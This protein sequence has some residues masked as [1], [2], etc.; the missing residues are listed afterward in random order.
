MQRPFAFMA[1][2]Y[3]NG[4]LR[5]HTHNP[6]HVLPSLDRRPSSTLPP[7]LPGTDNQDDGI[8][9]DPWWP[10]FPFASC[11]FT[12]CIVATGYIQFRIRPTF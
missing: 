10:P 9:S 3:W 1:L 6:L 11:P 8:S 7:P 4:I 12:S 2:I 5:G